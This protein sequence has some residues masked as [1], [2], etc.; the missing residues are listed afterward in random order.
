VMR[1]AIDL[2]LAIAIGLLALALID[3][4]ARAV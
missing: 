3:L 4:V 1:Q 2:A